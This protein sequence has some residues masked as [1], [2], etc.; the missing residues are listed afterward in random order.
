MIHVALVTDRTGSFATML[1]HPAPRLIEG[2]RII[3]TTLAEFDDEVEARA[4]L[5]ELRGVDERLR[6]RTVRDLEALE[7]HGLAPMPPPGP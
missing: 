6:E 3:V 2:G 1:T 4:F 7:R 5:C